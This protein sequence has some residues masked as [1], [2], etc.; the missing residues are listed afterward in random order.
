MNKIKLFFTLIMIAFAISSFA[1]ENNIKQ[2]LDLKNSKPV[3]VL[4]GKFYDSSILNEIDPNSISKVEVLKGDKS[5]SIYGKKAENGAIV[6]TL[7]S[8]GE[9]KTPEF[10][11]NELNFGDNVVFVLDEKIVEQEKI[12][13]LAPNK[14]KSMLVFKDAETL[15]KYGV[16]SGKTLVLIESN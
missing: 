13:L 6:I 2:K 15:K 11:F 14:I 1:Q 7:K 16:P 10:K 9:K 8:E 5:V 4:D 12:K 3:Y